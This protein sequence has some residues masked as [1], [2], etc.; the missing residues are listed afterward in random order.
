MKPITT[1]V[2]EW[3]Q[4]YFS[5][6]NIELTHEGDR[7]T[8]QFTAG[9]SDHFEY[10]CFV[11]VYEDRPGIM[12][13]QYAPFK[14]PRVHRTTVAELLARINYVLANGALGM[15]M[16]DGEIRY[17]NGV[18]IKG[19]VISIAMISELVELGLSILD[20]YLPAVAAVVYAG[21]SAEQA[22]SRAEQHRVAQG[23]TNPVP[24]ETQIRPWESFVGSEAI[25]SWSADLN[26]VLSGNEVDWALAGHATVIV[27]ED[28]NYCREILQRVAADNNL[29]F[30]VI[31]ASDVMDMSPPSGLQALK[32]M[33][34]YLEPGRWMRLKGED[35]ESDNTAENAR[36]FQSQ[37]LDWITD[38]D[39]LHPVVYVTSTAKLGNMTSRLRAVGGFDRYIALPQESL[40][41]LAEGFLSLI[42]RDCCSA[43]LQSATAKLGKL[44]K[45][46]SSEKRELALLCMRRLHHRENRPLEFID[47]VHAFSRNML[48]QDASTIETDE[49]R[50]QVAFH[51]AG[52]AVVAVLD[53]GG[54][55]VPDC[56]SI[57]PS[58]AFNGIVV[59]SYTFHHA[60]D[61]LNT[62]RNFR[63]NIRIC[64]AARAAEEIAFG[65]E[66]VSSASSDDLENASRSAFKAFACWGFVPRM[67]AGDRAARNLGVVFGAPSN[68]EM[69]HLEVLVREFLEQEYE[70]VKVMLENNRTLLDAVANRLL[71]EQM[72]DQGELSAI[73]T[74]NQ[75]VATAVAVRINQADKKQ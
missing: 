13:F 6:K 5:N 56:T 44:L 7:A 67:E 22:F 46:E 57:V 15:D 27:N 69:H 18:D 58:A 23:R 72:L 42:G 10:R 65:I 17:K 3:T 30:T 21:Q 9:D 62:Y 51:E 74:E 61:D 48:E 34:V 16:Q 47:L 4:A 70:V 29:N 19:G 12:L 63:H 35:G 60:H 45:D 1:V 71:S 66:N 37:L 43:A 28:Q 8:C 11:E 33:L 39:P 55:N 25:R 50:Q 68:S 38:F 54:K 40:S 75:A 14:V 41:I 53:S 26:S 36:R 24:E 59:E 73:F 2:R 52:H 31:A 32:P 49:L 20:Q 64:L